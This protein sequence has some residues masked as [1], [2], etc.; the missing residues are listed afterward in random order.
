MSLITPTAQHRK[1]G[2]PSTGLRRKVAGSM[3]G[4]VLVISVVLTAAC[5]TASP[6]PQDTTSVSQPAVKAKKPKVS[7]CNQVR[8]AFLTGT[9]KTQTKALK[10]LKADKNADATAREYAGYWL[11]RDKANKQLR[12]MDQ[13][14]IVSACSL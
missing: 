1:P 4:L 12:E 14:L 3:T 10:R 5:G 6:L 8:E 9:V 13:T 7:A 11:V 2:L